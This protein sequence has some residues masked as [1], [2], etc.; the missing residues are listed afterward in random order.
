MWEIFEGRT[1][2]ALEVRISSSG[3]KR[4]KYKRGETA[5]RWT[6]GAPLCG[7]RSARRADPTT[8]KPPNVA[9]AALSGCPSSSAHNRKIVNRSSGVP[10]SRLSASKIPRRMVAL[11]PK[12]RDR[13]IFSAI[14]QENENARRRD[15][16]KKVWRS[17]GLK[18]QPLILA[19]R[20]DLSSCLMK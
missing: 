6:T 4:T 17:I 10:L 1:F 13:G 16:L 8:V 11:P 9:G 20:W 12:P 5:K 19:C 2:R 7:V 18:N 14:E 15:C 3:T